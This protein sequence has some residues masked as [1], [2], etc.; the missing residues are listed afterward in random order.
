MTNRLAV[1]AL[2]LTFSLA[3]PALA[4][5]QRGGGGR[6]A[7]PPPAPRSAPAMRAAPAPRPAAP[8]APAGGF[9]L[10][11][12]I[13][14]P[15]AAPRTAAPAPR[16]AAPVARAGSRPNGVAYNRPSFTANTSGGPFRDRF[17]GPVIRNAHAGGGNYGWNHGIAWRP[18]PIYWG[19]GF[20][21]PFAIASL[22]GIAAYGD[23]EDD[24]DQLDYPSYQVDPDTPGAQLLAD[25]NLQQTP[26]GPPNLVVIWGPDNSVICAVPNDSVGP[27]DYQVDPDTFTLVSASP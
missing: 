4:L 6:P 13:A 22:G 7:A 12:D 2:A 25:Y 19:G 24:Q 21:G 27:G 11:R 14:P 3:L 23:Y 20:W 9:N 5:A 16:A 18:A 26:C 17:K 10:R 8:A 1:P 15:A